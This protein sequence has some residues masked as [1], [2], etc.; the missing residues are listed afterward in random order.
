LRAK[1]GDRRQGIV[2]E[3]RM[4]VIQFPYRAS[5]RVYSRLPQRSKTATPEERTAKAEAVITRDELERQVL[6]HLLAKL[7]PRAYEIAMEEIR[8]VMAGRR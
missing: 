2:R 8:K 6:A 7:N 5:R 4:S 1:F 3:I